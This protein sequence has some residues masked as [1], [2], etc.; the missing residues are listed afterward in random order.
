VAMMAGGRGGWVINHSLIIGGGGY[1]ITT[2]V[3]ATEGANRRSGP[4][5]LQFGYGRRRSGIPHPPQRRGTSASTRSS[6]AA[7]PTM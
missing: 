7:P 2:E 1:G 6:A 5:D 3:N 4:L